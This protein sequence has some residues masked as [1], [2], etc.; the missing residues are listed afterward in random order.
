MLHFAP[1]L[2]TKF[3]LCFEPHVQKWVIFVRC[4]PCVCE[5]FEFESPR[6]PWKKIDL[7]TDSLLLPPADC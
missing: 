5:T 1:F 3:F 4:R 7:G 2:S 6:L